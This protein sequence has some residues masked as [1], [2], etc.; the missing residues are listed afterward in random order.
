[1]LP[2]IKNDNKWISITPSSGK[3]NATVSVSV[4]ENELE[5]SR[6]GTISVNMLDKTIYVSI[7]QTARVFSVDID[8]ADLIFPASGGD[9]SFNIT[10]N[11]NWTLSDYPSWLTLSKTSGKGNQE[12]KA[13]ASENPNVT[14]RTGSI[15]LGIYGKDLGLWFQS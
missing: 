4:T 3:G 10:S 6:Q 13:T 2:K 5:E 14:E 7:S 8:K 11:T 1:M 12:I 15:T 9:I